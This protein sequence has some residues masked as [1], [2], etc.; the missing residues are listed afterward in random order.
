MGYSAE[1]AMEIIQPDKSEDELLNEVTRPMQDH[2]DQ[3]SFLVNRL[4]SMWELMQHDDTIFDLGYEVTKDA[5]AKHIALGNELTMELVWKAGFVN[6][7]NDC[8]TVIL[9]ILENGG[10]I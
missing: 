7:A 2:E 9:D 1:D 6:G 3:K 10:L 8:R 5:C 4:M